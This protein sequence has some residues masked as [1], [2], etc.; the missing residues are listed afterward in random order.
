MADTASICDTFFAAGTLVAPLKRHAPQDHWAELTKPDCKRLSDELSS[1]TSTLVVI[2]KQDLPWL[3]QHHFIYATWF[4]NLD[5]TA[6]IRIYIIPEDNESLRQGLFERHNLLSKGLN[7]L[8]SLLSLITRCPAAW[9]ASPGA[10]SEP[11]FFVEILLPSPLPVDMTLSGVAGLPAVPNGLRALKKYPMAMNSTL[12][13]YQVRSLA[14]MLEQEL[15]HSVVIDAT[16]SLDQLEACPKRSTERPSPLFAPIYSIKS[17]PESS[18]EASIFFIHPARLTL[19]RQPPEY[20][21]PRGGILSENMGTGKTVICIALILS[22]LDH[23]SQPPEKQPHV[24]Q[25]RIF[26]EWWLQLSRANP[27]TPT[28][29]E[30]T[31]IPFPCLVDIACHRARTTSEPLDW[32]EGAQRLAEHLSLKAHSEA[33]RPFY[34]DNSVPL[35]ARDDERSS[36]PRQAGPGFHKVFLT[37]ATLLLIPKM[38]LLQWRSELKKHVR[39]G[40]LRTL[41]VFKDTVIPGA[42]S[43]AKDFDVGLGVEAKRKRMKGEILSVSQVRWLRL[44]VDEGN[45]C[46]NVSEAMSQARGLSAERRWIVTGTPTMRLNS[47]TQATGSLLTSSPKTMTPNRACFTEYRSD[48]DKL[49]TMITG[50]LGVKVSRMIGGFHEIQSWS[51]DE[52]ALFK[53]NVVAPLCAST[54]EKHWSSVQVLQRMLEEVIIRHRKEDIEAELVLPPLDHQIVRLGMDA[55]QAITYNVIQSL[56]VVN[57]IDSERCGKDYFFHPVN[58]HLLKQVIV[59]LS[60]ACFWMMDRTELEERMEERVRNAYDSIERTRGRGATDA[61]VT[62]ITEAHQ[63]LQSAASNATWRSMMRK[64]D[65]PIRVRHVPKKVQLAWNEITNHFPDPPS[66]AIHTDIEPPADP[67]F[68]LHVPDF[69]QAGRDCLLGEERMVQTGLRFLQTLELTERLKHGKE[70]SEKRHYELQLELAFEN[71]GVLPP[72]AA[73]VVVKADYRCMAGTLGSLISTDQPLLQATVTGTTSP[74]ADFIVAEILR[75]PED[76][77]LIFSESPLSLNLLREALDVAKIPN[78]LLRTQEFEKDKLGNMVEGVRKFEATRTHRAL[79]MELKDGARGLNLTSANRVIFVEPVWQP[80]VESQA[81]KRAHRLGQLRDITVQTLVME[82]TAEEKMLVR[83]NS[84]GRVEKTMQED[85]VM[86]D[87]I[88]NPRFIVASN[89]SDPRTVI[90]LPMFEADYVPSTSAAGPVPALPIQVLGKRS[91]PPEPTEF[92]LHHQAKRIR[93]VL[94]GD[95][96]ATVA[97]IVH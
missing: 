16:D 28:A 6:S 49:S 7:R 68:M 21:P 76:R 43:L 20:Q 80:D 5:N 42:A 41:V 79:L 58:A 50:F 46:A 70:V 15:R 10:T 89:T 4:V 56:V 53:D 9:V 64:V 33:F 75:S 27:N 69:R 88:K 40:V 26:T 54:P 94:F 62:L 36:R 59:N 74:K 97:P 25:H 24:S 96:P 61:D 37:N 23:L 73:D 82:G 71:G 18:Q 14:R 22:T 52:K 11:D 91:A 30:S 78:V 87:F 31:E 2:L 3:I 77:F 8:R 63:V 29:D 51:S 1:R 17:S 65:L 81:V 90:D 35:A 38:L 44:I 67:F 66:D 60:Q 84:P 83:R 85:G 34:L 13:K 95:E 32:R 72:L 92:A 45:V 55:Y 47:E 57:A 39:P 48:L 93:R 86:A 12:Y 19:R